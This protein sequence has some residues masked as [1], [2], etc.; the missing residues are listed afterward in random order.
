[1]IHKSPC[2]STS[3]NPNSFASKA[4][5]QV[6]ATNTYPYPMKKILGL[7]FFLAPLYQKFILINQNSF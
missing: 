4:C 1:M 3:P 6:R 2:F 7:I 5:I